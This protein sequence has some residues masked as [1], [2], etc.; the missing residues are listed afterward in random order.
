MFDLIKAINITENRLAELHAHNDSNGYH[1]QAIEALEMVLNDLNNELHAEMLI[2]EQYAQEF[3]E[4]RG[5]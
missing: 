4:N 3:N 2:M 5:I 1:F